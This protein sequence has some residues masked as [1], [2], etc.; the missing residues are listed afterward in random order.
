MGISGEMEGKTAKE[1]YAGVGGD[2]KTVK[3]VYAGL[4]G[5]PKLV[6]AK[7]VVGEEW[8]M[9]FL[10]STA[11]WRSVTY[12]N[13]NLWQSH[14]MT[15]K[16]RTARM[17]LYGKLQHCHQLRTGDQSPMETGNSWW[18]H[19][20]VTKQHTAQMELHGKQQHY[21]QLHICNQSPM[22]MGNML[23][24]K[25]EATMRCTA[26]MELHGKL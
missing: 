5:V 1:I 12:G 6:W 21:H 4:N 26:R 3:E 11:R 24:P 7:C 9:A 25:V 8:Q 13:G 23:R 22:E 17:E 19:I 20:A 15:V 18:S 2:V 10:P 16:H 14:I